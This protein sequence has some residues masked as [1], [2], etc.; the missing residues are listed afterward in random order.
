[1]YFLDHSNHL[2]ELQDYN[3]EPI[4][5]EYD[6]NP[7]IFWICDAY[8]NLQ[9]SVNNYYCKVI[10][11]VYEIEN[12]SNFD[13][14]SI[15]D[16]LDIE[17][18]CQSE[19][20]SLVKANK[21]QEAINNSK[22]ILEYIDPIDKNDKYLN[23]LSSDNDDDIIILKVNNI[24]KTTNI[25]K[26]YII[27]PIYVLAFAKYQ[28]TWTSNIMIHITHKYTDNQIWCP[29]TVGGAF[30]EE[31]EQLIIH[32]QN[33]G[34]NLPKDILKA[35]N[36]A[37]YYNDAFDEELYNKK[38]KEYMINYMDIKGQVGNYNSA[39]KSLKWFG[40]ENII[41]IYKLFE[42]DNEFKK[43]Y[44]R[45][46][47]DIH[48]DFIKAYKDFIH[49]QL[50]SLQFKLNQEKV[51]EFGK[52][53][54]DTQ[55]LSNELWG[56]GNPLLIN[57]N[58]INL[59]KYTDEFLKNQ[60][61]GY[62]TTYF[63][64][65]FN[66][67]LFKLSCLAYYYDKYFLPI[68][69]NLKNLYIEQ[70]VY[71]NHIKQI[72]CVVEDHF[73]EPIINTQNLPLDTIEFPKED[74]LYFTHKIV[75]VDDNLNQF[76][77]YIPDID[78]SEYDEVNYDYRMISDTAITI[79]I[80]FKYHEE[81]S[82]KNYYNVLLYLVNE[83]DEIIYDTNFSFIQTESL[84]YTFILYPKFIEYLKDKPLYTIINKKYKLYLNIN[85]THFKYEFII[86]VPEF[87]I[88]IGTLEY[89]YWE[90]EI[91]ILNDIYNEHKDE[92]SEIKF[93]FEF[94]DKL[95]DNKLDITDYIKNHDYNNESM[96]YLTKFSQ[97]DD[98]DDNNKSIKF[99]LFMHHPN[100]VKVNNAEFGINK[101]Y[102]TSKEDQQTDNYKE[103]I[104]NYVNKYYK[105]KINITQNDKFLNYVHL[106]ELQKLQKVKI[107]DELKLYYNI[108]CLCDNILI[109]KDKSDNTN[110]I[111]ISKVTGSGNDI[112]N[113]YSDHYTYLKHEI[114]SE[115]NTTTINPPL[116]EEKALYY[117]IQ[118]DIN[119][120]ILN[121]NADSLYSNLEDRN[122]IINI[123][124]I[125][126]NV[127]DNVSNLDNIIYNKFEEDF[128]ISK[129]K[130][131]NDKYYYDDIALYYK[132]SYVTKNNQGEYE[133]YTQE[134]R[135]NNIIYLK[136]DLFYYKIVTVMNL[137][138]YYDESNC[139]EISN[140]KCS[141]TLSLG[142]MEQPIEINNV[143]LYESASYVRYKDINHNTY[144]THENPSLFWY[145]INKLNEDINYSFSN[146][147]MI[148][149]YNDGQL[150][151]D[152]DNN[153]ECNFKDLIYLNYL[154][155]DLTGCIGQYKL[156]CFEYKTD[157]SEEISNN[158]ILCADIK[159]PDNP[160]IIT[161][162]SNDN[163][164]NTLTINGHEEYVYVYFQINSNNIDNQLI[165]NPHLY[166][167]KDDYDNIKYQEDSIS[168]IELYNKFF[169]KKYSLYYTINNEPNIIKNVW[170]SII[171]IDK[172]DSYDAYLMH[173]NEIW[174]MMF[175]SKDT[176]D[177]T[178][179]KYNKEISINVD[180]DTNKTEEYL[181][182]HVETKKMFLINRM[183]INYVEN[184]NHF[185]QDDIIVCSLY[186]NDILPT[187]VN[188]SSKWLIKPLSYG[189]DK[190]IKIYG[191]TNSAILSIPNTRN[192]YYKGYYEI[193]V[194]YSFDNNVINNQKIKKRILIK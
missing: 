147:N 19:I 163:S 154:C 74:V 143:K 84:E 44:I 136:L 134:D 192:E 48:T 81:D 94:C 56:E 11:V 130:A 122:T 153:E 146:E 125:I 24:D 128:D 181:L 184:I 179:Y 166:R 112:I 102:L 86:K 63:K 189:I 7:Y 183:K 85:N 80:K 186:N 111:I 104:N 36:G 9:L 64:Y 39:I 52:I 49:S 123:G 57:Y 129:L 79:P 91:N 176:C 108:N 105:E 88:Q 160:D 110:K 53:E 117:I 152:H 31:Y 158:F 120:N 159:I 188:L 96:H 15:S 165:V 43:Q 161:C 10:N 87:N 194:N 50:I 71:A 193:Q 142:N 180:I 33:M 65:S 138:G 107:N 133:E 3:K 106:Y 131:E 67:L 149:P 22:N 72:N 132:A 137:F 77:T 83:Y 144:I 89:K 141:V 126:Y 167:I 156:E 191:H 93:I 37:S 172:N 8:E 162:Y 42:T 73:I 92:N 190:N 69:I 150:H 76:S 148:M 78:I 170:D 38:I 140:N 127:G 40:F 21:F 103:I 164:K 109:T 171:K 124:Y 113:T 66:E 54:L 177:N 4:G 114:Q 97:I 46:Y 135:N 115:E 1:M 30:N 90:N 27:I 34:V 20:F 35:V 32:G 173:D 82:Y 26:N 151:N 59:I 75:W 14:Q 168:Q 25:Q 99:N 182:K 51:D 119:G 98:I 70:K 23:K 60:E 45:D 116:K 145:S 139:S 175:I 55:D 100:L 28:G 185:N 121:T 18:Y 118:R 17:I 187:Q 174:Y 61:F 62:K 157:G 5:Y 155:K 12:I 29:I 58:D 95:E 16:L 178:D 101:K 6:Q 169:K 2:F 13:T 47:F 41:S 68:F